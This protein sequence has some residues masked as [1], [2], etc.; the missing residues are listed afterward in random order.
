M[1]DKAS[2][3]SRQWGW[4]RVLPRMLQ[5]LVCLGALTSGIVISILAYRAQN[6]SPLETSIARYQPVDLTDY[7]ALDLRAI[8]SDLVGGS[9]TFLAHD[10]IPY[11]QYAL[12][13]DAPFMRKGLVLFVNGVQV[14][15]AAG[16]PTAVYEFDV[17]HDDGQV[18]DYPFDKYELSLNFFIL[19]ASDVNASVNLLAKPQALNTS[20]FVPISWTIRAAVP[21]LVFRGQVQTNTTALGV[22]QVSLQISRA[23]T[24]RWFHLMIFGFQWMQSILF[25]MATVD[26]IS[27]GREMDLSVLMVGAQ[28]LFS[29]PRLREAEPGVPDI[30]TFSDVIG[31]FWN[32]AFVSFGFVT[33]SMYHLYKGSVDTQLARN[34]AAARAIDVF[35]QQRWQKNAPRGRTLRSPEGDQ[36][37]D[38]TYKQ[39]PSIDGATLGRSPQTDAPHQYHELTPLD[40]VFVTPSSAL[41]D[42]V[43]LGG[44]RPAIVGQGESSHSLMEVDVGSPEPLTDYHRTTRHTTTLPER[45]S[46]S[47]ETVSS[48]ITDMAQT[49]RG[50]DEAVR[51]D[52]HL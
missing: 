32:I 15:F 20:P 25:M 12:T 22:G 26:L 42:P 36:G 29:L 51:D 41:P 38:D 31:F 44:D 52:V 13:G 40:E 5:T 48:D 49:A 39:S 28:A 2:K 19:A 16:L 6:Y 47:V 24:T 37:S 45:I 8:S 10:V 7:V 43:V 23:R 17:T 30:G 50:S 21:S 46:T 33:L 4:Q 14:V 27:Q 34:R 1:A 3:P 11:G 9:T 35:I 18:N